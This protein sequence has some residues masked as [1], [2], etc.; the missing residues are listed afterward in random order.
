MA[1][2]ARSGSG[3]L[4]R[5]TVHPDL[6]AAL[7]AERVAG[8]GLEPQRTAG[9]P[10][11]ARAPVTTS[12]RFRKHVPKR[13]DGGTARETALAELE[14]TISS[15]L[16]RYNR[17]AD[18][19]RA[20]AVADRVKLLGE[21][22]HA[23]YK[24]FDRLHISD[25]DTEPRARYMRALMQS[26]DREH[27]NVVRAAIGA[28]IAPVYEAGL[29]EPEKARAGTLWT[30]VSQGQGMLQIE[31]GG[32]AAF[33]EKTLSS[34]AKIL[35]TMTGR[36]I[37]EFLDRPA[38]V[39]APHG[40]I[41][42]NL[43]THPAWGTQLTGYETF[44]VPQTQAL[45]SAGIAG[46]TAPPGEISA[47]KELSQVHGLGRGDAIVNAR[48]SYTKLGAAPD[49]AQLRHYPLVANA[50]QY[51]RAVLEGAQGFSVNYRGATEYYKFGTGEGNALVMQYGQ[52]SRGIGPG[53]VEVISPDFLML[54]HEMGHAVRVR[55]GG[56]AR[57][58]QFNWFGE[59]SATWE[60]RPEEMSNV[61]GI[62]NPVRQESGI[63]TRST[64]MTWKVMV[65]QPLLN[66]VKQT[67]DQ[68]G[69]PQGAPQ[70]IMQR[71]QAAGFSDDEVWSWAK[72][73]QASKKLFLCCYH[74][75][76]AA[77]F[78]PTEKGE[79]AN[80]L[81]GL[82]AA[83]VNKLRGAA[84]TFF[85]RFVRSKVP[86]MLLPYLRLVSDDDAKANALMAGLTAAQKIQALAYLHGNQNGLNA[87]KALLHFKSSARTGTTPTQRAA[88]RV[89]ALRTLIAPGG[90]LMAAQTQRTTV[91]TT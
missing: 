73:Q 26:L 83:F 37:V 76:N 82:S 78:S 28:G 33:Q 58:K 89:E 3:L 45:Q 54:A 64:Y 69:L 8:S 36:D 46:A 57:E 23:I 49:P 32:N 7:T 70:P 62:E 43:P 72:T 15:R 75:P 77:F 21:L 9:K 90:T 22:D 31:G 19:D 50:A 2:L 81:D 55:G 5:G 59:T 79:R 52:F 74:D 91:S 27:I 16:Y 10:A 60:N 63:T 85:D 34:I 71:L 6:E 1:R 13:P 17:I 20:A 80:L 41:P 35:H 24:W 18:D 56:Y 42:G 12:K 40:I 38:P 29:S 25:F 47:N 84:P 48:V 87:V 14:K 51:N 65:G 53:N 66:Q 86:T 68:V 88:A 44:I 11:V 39:A 4:P 61:I 67:F 30:S